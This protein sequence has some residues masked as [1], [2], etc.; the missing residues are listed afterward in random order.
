MTGRQKTDKGFDDHSMF[1]NDIKYAI[2]INTSNM[3]Q[4]FNFQTPRRL[5]YALQVYY[6]IGRLLSQVSEYEY[7]PEIS[8]DGRIHVHGYITFFDTFEYHVHLAH[9]LNDVCN[10]KIK[11]IDDEERWA[12]YIKKDQGIVEQCLKVRNL[13]YRYSNTCETV[14]IWNKTII[15]L[16]QRISKDIRLQEE[17]YRQSILNF[18]DCQDED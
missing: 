2:T 10:I 6:N 14:K 8:K 12:E 4:H 13:P 16:K 3:Y 11:D 15:D 7:F 17:V 18:I 9:I 1:K 5:K